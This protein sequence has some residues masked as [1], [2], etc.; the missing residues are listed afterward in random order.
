MKLTIF[1]AVLLFACTCYAITIRP[2]Y[3]LKDAPT[4]FAK[5]MIDYDRHYASMADTLQRYENFKVALQDIN[6]MNAMSSPYRPSDATF[7]IND[8]ADISK[9]EF[10]NTYLGF[11][12]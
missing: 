6:R 4:L 8:F 5:F 9:E 11:I 10:K 1:T 3:D 12:P 7:D 2:H